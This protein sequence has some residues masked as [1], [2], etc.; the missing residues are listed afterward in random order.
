MFAFLLCPVL[1]SRPVELAWVWCLST[2]SG[3]SARP[4]QVVVGV[5]R[6]SDRQ[7]PQCSC[8]GCLASPSVLR[9]GGPLWIS[10][11]TSEVC[12]RL[13]YC[14]ADWLER[15]AFGV[16]TRAAQMYARAVRANSH[17]QDQVVAFSWVPSCLTSDSCLFPPGHRPHVSRS[18]GF[19]KGVGFLGNPAQHPLAGGSLLIVSTNDESR[20]SSYSV[21]MICF[22]LL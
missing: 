9:E 5:R 12:G 17:S 21:P 14:H 1:V 20:M 22:A 10:P 8:P 6:F 3:G 16:C 19:P 15:C 18:S 2:V 4:G 11:A 13:A 7:P